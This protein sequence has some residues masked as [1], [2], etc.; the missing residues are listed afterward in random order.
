MSRLAAFSVMSQELAFPARADE[1]CAS[2]TQTVI[3]LDHIVA[4]DA[5]EI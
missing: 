2:R 3:V 4:G 5:A 1:N